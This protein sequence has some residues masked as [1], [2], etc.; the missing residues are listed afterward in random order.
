MGREGRGGGGRG[1][2]GEALEA[3][4]TEGVRQSVWKRSSVDGTMS[5]AELKAGGARGGGRSAQKRSSAAAASWRLG[6]HGEGS[7]SWR[8][9]SKLGEA[10]VEHLA[11]EEVNANLEFG[12]S[13]SLNLYKVH[14]NF[15]FVDL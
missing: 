10:V 8:S 14:W 7:G 15:E 5:R 6:Q 1:G 2:R 9:R 11:D 13:R 12:I 3:S 4:G